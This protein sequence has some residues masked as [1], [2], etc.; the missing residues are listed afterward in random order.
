MSEEHFSGSL[1]LEVF[2]CCGPSAVL[3]ACLSP[4]DLAHFTSAA[5]PLATRCSEAREALWRSYFLRRWGE[6]YGASRRTS[7]RVV[8]PE[9]AETWPAPWPLAV[10]FCGASSVLDHLFWFVPFARCAL[11]IDAVPP[12]LASSATWHAACLVRAGAGGEARVARCEFCDAL[13]VAPPPPAPQ[14]LRG[15]W[16]CPCA[17]SPRLAHRA[18]LERR[19]RASAGLARC[20]AC[21]GAMG[22]ASRFPE[23]LVELLVATF[24]E[25][26]WVLRRGLVLLAFYA[27]LQG[28]AVHYGGLRTLPELW[29]LFLLMACLASI[30]TTDRFQESVRKSLA[31]PPGKH[32]FFGLFAFFALQIYAVCLRVLTPS[33]WVEAAENI[34]CLQLLHQAHTL[35]YNSKIGTLLFGFVATIFAVSASGVIFLFWKTSLRVPTVADVRRGAHSLAAS[36]RVFSPLGLTQLDA[37]ARSPESRCCAD[38]GLCQLGLCLDNT[39]M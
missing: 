28:L 36:P 24:R 21:S 37:A 9:A 32:R 8:R 1:P 4:E 10:G 35:L 31:T 34:P 29:H 20:G 7:V 27:W 39:C 5:R 11:R 12:A 30:S 33:S 22:A 17:C 6:G 18:C 2:E 13:E 38:C 25:W 3:Q 23:T 26:R 19:Q 16:V 14:H 15:R